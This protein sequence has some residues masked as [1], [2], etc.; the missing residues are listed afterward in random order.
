MMEK[1][2]E[3]SKNTAIPFTE[4]GFMDATGIHA[5]RWEGNVPVRPHSHEFLEVAMLAKG[6]CLHSWQGVDVRLVPGEIGR[7]HV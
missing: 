3:E 4:S 1:Q 7:A 5:M 6:S 2:R